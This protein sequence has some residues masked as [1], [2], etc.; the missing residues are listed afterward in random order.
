MAPSD[1]KR[2]AHEGTDPK[3]SLGADIAAFDAIDALVR[4]EDVAKLARESLRV[5]AKERGAPLEGDAVRAKIEA[6]GLSEDDTGTDA[7]DVAAVLSRGPEDDAE[8]ALAGALA[9]HALATWEG[10]SAEAIAGE[11]VRLASDT[12]FDATP[13]VARALGARAEE[14]W[15][16]VAERVRRFEAGKLRTATRG[17]MAVACAALATSSAKAARTA[18]EKLAADVQDPL[19]A[20]ILAP[21][22]AAGESRVEGELAPAPRGAVLTT[23]LAVTGLLLVTGLARLLAR[24]VLSYRRPADVTL[25][26]AGVRIRTRTELLGRTLRDREIT[27]GKDGLVR[28]A[29][30]VR[31]PRLGLYA[32][33]LFLALGS[34]VGVGAVVDGVRSA[35]PS[36][37]LAGLG[38]V[39]AGIAL[40]LG[41]SSLW[42]GAR[43]KCRVVFLPRRGRALCLSG[44][45]PQ[46][47]DE[48]LARLRA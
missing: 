13:L 42:P 40:D 36:V 15:G 31:F 14:V 21:S 4:R 20:A 41:L 28:A 25:S 46:R 1:A 7:G 33:L 22:A 3:P 23:L 24:F 48:A 16:A 43:G 37:L 8:R 38:I 17:Q 18:R 35:S 19:L 26:S 30:E 44:V 2:D 47:A 29:R 39:A 11:L 34:Y 12:A 27:I 32:G 6:L 9:A 10:A 5:G 45:D